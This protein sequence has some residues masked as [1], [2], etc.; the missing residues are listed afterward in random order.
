M[1][2]VKRKTL[3]S[4]MGGKAADQQAQEATQ[5]APSAN[6]AVIFGYYGKFAQGDWEG[7]KRDSFHPD[8]TWNMPGHHPLAGAHKGVDAAIAFLRALYVAGVHVDNV[9]V[10]ELD[11]GVTVCEK[12]LGHA[13]VDGEEFSFPTCTTYEIRDG[14]IFNV[15]VHTGDPQAAERFMWLRF[16]LKPVPER[17]EGNF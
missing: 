8:M 17:L 12:H 4:A 15:Q 5:P 1:A 13:N 2:H 6:M 11:D 9:H 10:G 7:L 16:P 14:R 3:V